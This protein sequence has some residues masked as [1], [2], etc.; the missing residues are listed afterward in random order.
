M[1]PDY[2]EREYRLYCEW[3]DALDE[4]FNLLETSSETRSTDNQS[5]LKD[6]RKRVGKDLK[7]FQEKLSSLMNGD[8][9]G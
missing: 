7:G 2:T 3:S 5:Q 8:D 6:Y 1:S 4:F 9:D